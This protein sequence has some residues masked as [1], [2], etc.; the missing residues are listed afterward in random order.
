MNPI[1]NFWARG[2]DIITEKVCDHPI[3]RHGV[4]ENED[5]LKKWTKF[6]VSEFRKI[7]K[8]YTKHLLSKESLSRRVKLLIEKQ[9]EK[10]RY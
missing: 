5:N 6:V 10:I 1:E 2:D 9:C 7:P 8:K 3:W 4:A